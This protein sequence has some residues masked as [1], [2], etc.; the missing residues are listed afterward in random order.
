[1]KREQYIC[2]VCGRQYGN[3]ERQEKVEAIRLNAMVHTPNKGAK[4]HEFIVEEPCY[5]CASLIMET[6]V[7][8][9]KDAVNLLR[10]A[11][12]T[13]PALAKEP[14]PVTTKKKTTRKNVD[15]KAPM[16]QTS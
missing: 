5:K 12:A 11:S 2:D 16:T 10:E 4:Q 13:M 3:E 6:M 1:M 9:G 14:A 7:G 8:A 15:N